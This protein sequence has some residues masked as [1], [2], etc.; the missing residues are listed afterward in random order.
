MEEKGE[1]K[2]FLKHWHNKALT[3]IWLSFIITLVMITTGYI[4]DYGRIGACVLGLVGAYF[5]RRRYRRDERGKEIRDAMVVVIIALSILLLLYVR[6][7]LI[8]KG[9]ALFVIT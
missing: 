7:L 4:T 1:Q 6:S 9:I 5:F 8:S 3:L 2:D